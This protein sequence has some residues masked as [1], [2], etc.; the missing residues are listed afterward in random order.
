MIVK[1]VLQLQIKLYVSIFA[2]TNKNFFYYLTGIEPF[3]EK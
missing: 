3:Q 1:K 2:P